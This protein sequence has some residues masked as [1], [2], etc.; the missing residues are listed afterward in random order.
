LCGGG[1]NSA[2]ACEFGRAAS[3][4]TTGASGVVLIGLRCSRRVGFLRVEVKRMMSVVLTV[5][6][7]GCVITA[8][9]V[10]ALGVVS[11]DRR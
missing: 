4:R 11:R 5:V 10:L 6:T 8:L 3:N 9:A 7:I 2:A 1:W